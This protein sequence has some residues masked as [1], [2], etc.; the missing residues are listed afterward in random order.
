MS[1]TSNPQTLQQASPVKPTPTTA[2]K[3]R[4]PPRGQRTQSGVRRWL[5]D[6][7][8]WY[9]IEDEPILTSTRQAEA[10][11]PALVSTHPP[12]AGPPLG[13][14]LATG[15]PITCDP[16]E[17]YNAS[18]RRLFSPNVA[19]LGDIGMGKSSLAKTQYVARPLAMGRSVAVFD[20]KRQEGVGEYSRLAEATGGTVIRFDRAGGAVINLLDPRI[21]QHDPSSDTSGGLVGQDRLLL[22]VA[23]FAH[24]DLT[25]RERAALRAAH[26]TALA[27]ARERDQ[28]ATIVDVLDA[29][30]APTTDS[31]PRASLAEG[32][33]VT[34]EDLFHWGLDLALDLDRFVDGDLSGLIDGPT[35]A[36]DDSELDLS[37]RLIV[38]DTSALDEDSPALSLVMAVMSTYLTAVWSQ[39]PGQRLLVIE[40]GYHTVH[41]PAVAEIFR[42]LAKRGRGIGL[43]TVSAF[44]HISDVP[45]SS[46]AMTLLRECGMVHV[47]R[48]SRADDA[49]DA[50]RLF[51]LPQRLEDELAYLGLGVHCLRIESEAPA[52]VGPLR[53]ETEAELSDTDQAMGDVAD[54]RM[55]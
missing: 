33:R 28:T 40:E 46:A 14:D 26:H 25:A 19:I 17:L 23:E 7:L 31:L 9:E 20:R 51:R 12:L 30:Y 54:G 24:G 6:R 27:R 43:S 41:I 22:M 10:L 36:A 2:P 45:D 55:S 48:Q 3:Q 44:H 47:F 37:S 15:V 32:G 18:P 1:T 39:T 8:G 21:A 49:A 5:W 42:S 34:V 38:V 52:Y 13:F 53:T 29:L 16:H 4:K 50:V 11:N 35:R